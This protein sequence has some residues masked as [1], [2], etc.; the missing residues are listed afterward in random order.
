MH[1]IKELAKKIYKLIF[2]TENNLT[3]TVSISFLIT[4]II[5]FLFALLSQGN[6]NVNNAFIYMSALFFSLWILL[7]Q[8][9][10]SVDKFVCELVRLLLFSLILIYSLISCWYVIQDKNSVNFT[11]VILCSFG[12]CLCSIYFVSK[13]IDILNF[14]KKVFLQIKSKLFNTTEPATTKAT[15]LIENVTAFLVAIGGFTVAIKAITETIF[16]I[17]DYFK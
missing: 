9:A 5:L 13:V 3:L 11:L 14:I 12:L 8:G 10:D 1:K 2:G 4:A 16:Q 7:I 15:A 17:I 6:L